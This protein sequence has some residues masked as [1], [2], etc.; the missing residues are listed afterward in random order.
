MEW[1]A[2][3]VTSPLAGLCSS[4]VRELEK[5][6][7]SGAIASS[8]VL[9]AADDPGVNIGSG[10]ATVNAL[11]MVTEM[12]SSQQGFTVVNADT[13]AKARI[14]I[15]HLGGPFLCDPCGKAFTNF[16]ATS[17]TS[18]CSLIASNVD[19]LLATMDKLQ[20]GGPAGVWVCS[21]QMLLSIPDDYT[22]DWSSLSSGIGCVAVPGTK[23]YARQHGVYRVDGENRVREIV[24]RGDAAAI[25]STQAPDGTVPLVSG[26]VWMC[27][28]T[29][30]R[31]LALHTISPLDGCTYI[32]LDSGAAPLSMS[33]FLDIIAAALPFDGDKDADPFIKACEDELHQRAR[34]RLRSHLHDLPVHAII[35]NDAKHVYMPESFAAHRDSLFL[36]SPHRQHSSSALNWCHLTHAF[37]VRS[38]AA[39]TKVTVINSIL[40]PNI[41]VADGAAIVHSHLS[42]GW[43]VGSNCYLLGIDNSAAPVA[44]HDDMALL[45]IHLREQHASSAFV[46]VGANDT[47]DAVASLTFCNRPMAEFLSA[48]GITVSELWSDADSAFSLRTARLFPIAKFGAE[49]TL[50]DL[51]W[52]QDP[53]STPDI[54]ACVQEWK[55]SWRVSIN[56]I[57][58]AVDVESEFEWRDAL[59]MEIASRNVQRALL[60][61]TPPRVDTIK[62]GPSEPTSYFLPTFKFFAMHRNF[63]ILSK[64]D[65][66]AITTSSPGVAARALA[67]MSDA[68]AAFS[69]NRGGLRSGPGHNPE[70]APA[71]AALDAGRRA[72][73]VEMMAATRASWL[74]TPD[75]L[76]RAAR[77]YEAAAQILIRRAV[78]S[79]FEFVQTRDAAMPAIG[80]WVTARCAS[81]I[82]IAGGWSDTPPVTYEHGGAVVNA[83]ITIN[84]E[85]PIVVRAR[86]IKDPHIRLVLGSGSSA[87]EVSVTSVAQVATYTQ[88]HTPGALIKAALCCAKVVS[89]TDDDSLQQQLLKVLGGGLELHS[90]TNLPTG[91][92][93]GTSSIL[94]GAVLAVVYRVSGRVVDKSSLNHATLYLEQL[95]TTGGGWQDQVGGLCGGVKFTRSAPSLP[96][97]I[98]VDTLPLTPEF[99]QT[100]SAHLV[101]VCVCVC[102]RLAKNLLQEVVRN[103]YA[104]SAVIVENTDALVEN[105]ERCAQAF[106]D[107]DLAA[108][109]ECLNAYRCQNHST[110]MD[111]FAP[112]AYGQ[113]LAGA[114]GGGFMYV[115]TKEPHA[116]A[117]FDTLIE[118]HFRD[119]GVTCYDVALD[120]EGLVVTTDE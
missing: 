56:D 25:A 93:L 32:G 87:Q 59:F 67:C 11:L 98:D 5:R 107:E 13:I 117:T 99:I 48:T 113:A 51:L 7:K 94:A 20:R 18:D 73:G 88:P 78:M 92:G 104:R 26:V 77:H 14:L 116:R 21:S 100:F 82:D 86:R 69:D 36:K 41:T 35:I 80:R 89:M 65:H 68:L 57:I 54:R 6:R 79:A 47:F 46:L 34:A 63:T 95:M 91:S 96:L 60:F 84:G 64:L 110:L 112:Y 109:G 37:G 9:V 111:R 3:V 28:T 29:A 115:I 120:E 15:L 45:Q 53:A 27:P 43:S 85:K 66:V 42:S 75:A 49:V 61:P 31:M 8:T 38:L 33:L 70:F 72:E 30:E 12:L 71:L 55:R 2:I 19:Q 23:E 44:L 102:T 16:G 24:Y 83:A 90:E 119:T 118:E 76:I 101:C 105:A 4:F 39:R 74:S 22:M 50:S 17:P 62:G 103:W 52:M 108:I 81:R 58:N 1:T 106:R 97:H 114:G 40:S 10:G